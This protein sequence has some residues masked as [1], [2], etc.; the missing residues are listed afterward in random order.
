MASK[1]EL[2]RYF[3]ELSWSIYEEALFTQWISEDAETKKQLDTL[4]DEISVWT[5]DTFRRIVHTDGS[6]NPSLVRKYYRDLRADIQK[7]ADYFLEQIL[8][9]GGLDE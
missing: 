5:D 1:K 7:K 4:M 3:A 9:N 6:K 2:K 8:D